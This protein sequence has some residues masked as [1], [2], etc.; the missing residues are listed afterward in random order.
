M[1]AEVSLQRLRGGGNEATP[2][3][4]RR[5]G[6]RM[7]NELRNSAARWLPAVVLLALTALLIGGWLLFPRLAA[8][9]HRQDCIAGGHMNCGD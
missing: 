1:R 5:S 8:Y 3:W 9:M 4:G 7:K 6:E 2:K